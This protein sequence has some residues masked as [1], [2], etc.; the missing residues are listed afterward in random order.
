[1]SH[2]HPPKNLSLP[3]SSSLPVSS[4]GGRTV[5][6]KTN[7]QKEQNVTSKADETCKEREE[8]GTNKYIEQG[9]RDEAKKGNKNAK[10]RR[11]DSKEEAC[12]RQ[13]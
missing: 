4:T 3:R 7:S 5:G 8:K 11:F 10:K 1:V 9:I 6:T 12:E 2:S 13:D